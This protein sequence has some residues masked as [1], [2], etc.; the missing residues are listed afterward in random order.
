MS[1]LWLIPQMDIQHC[2]GIKHV[3]LLSCLPVIQDDHF[4]APLS[5][6]TASPTPIQLMISSQTSLRKPTSLEW[7]FL[8]F[9][10][11]IY[12]LTSP[13][14]LSLLCLRP[15]PLH[16]LRTPCTFCSVSLTLFSNVTSLSAP[17]QLQYPIGG[18]TRSFSYL[19]VWPTI[20][21][22]NSLNNS[23][24]ITQEC[25][26]GSVRDGLCLLH[27]ISAC[28]TPLGLRGLIHMSGDTSA[29]DVRSAGAWLG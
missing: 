29:G 3:F 2:S 18:S 6:Q 10:H 8:I 26:R 11:Q 22:V 9:N 27:R 28:T 25:G 20:P 5:P 1:I 24:F 7:N 19:F 16:G 17:R 15:P 21:K 13:P 12:S 14:S 23:H 4:I